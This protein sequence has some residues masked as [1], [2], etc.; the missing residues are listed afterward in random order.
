MGLVFRVIQLVV[1]FSFPITAIIGNRVGDR[2]SPGNVLSARTTGLL[3]NN[4]F[5]IPLTEDVL[6]NFNRMFLPIDVTFG[7]SFR[8][9]LFSGRLFSRR[10]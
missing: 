4:F 5:P 6:L 1:I 3:T 8:N 10:G 7:I 9:G 2:N